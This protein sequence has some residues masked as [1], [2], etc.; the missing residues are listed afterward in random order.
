[1]FRLGRLTEYAVRVLGGLSQQDTRMSALQI[2]EATGLEQPTVSKILKKLAHTG[3]V[4]STRGA[5]GG[6]ELLKETSEISIAEIISVMEGPVALTDCVIH[7]G[8]CEQ[9]GECG[10]RP[11]W[12]RLSQAVEEALHSMSLAEMLN[13]SDNELLSKMAS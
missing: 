10:L 12:A 7:N 6:Y 8:V 9:S 2:A 5:H 4:Q 1:M 13:T 3:L 11:N